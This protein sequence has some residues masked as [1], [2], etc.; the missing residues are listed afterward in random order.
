[1]TPMDII[2]FRELLTTDTGVQSGKL[3]QIENK[4]AT[5]EKEINNKISMF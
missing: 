4:I 5:K 1:M 3:R 2:E